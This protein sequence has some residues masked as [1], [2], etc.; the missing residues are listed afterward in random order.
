MKKLLCVFVLINLLP[1]IALAF[2]VD[3]IF[4]WD[5]D[6][7]KS[8][9]TFPCV[10]VIGGSN[11]GSYVGWQ[12]SRWGDYD[13]FRQRVLWD[14][15]L[16]GS[17]QMI[18]IDDF[19][20]YVQTSTDVA[21]NP[22]NYFVAVWEDSSYRPEKFT[23]IWC[24]VHTNDP[25]L[26]YSGAR[27]QKRPS[28]GSRLNGYF[29]VSWT[30]YDAG[31]YP[32]VYC[33]R[34]DSDG[35]Y[36][37]THTVRDHDSIR[38]YVPESR[39]AF[40]DSGFIVVYEDSSQDGTSRS[41]YGQ[42]R[43]P[44]GALLV[45]HKKLSHLSGDF[46]N[47]QH[48]DVAINEQGNMVVVWQDNRDGDW[49]IYAQRFQA[50]RNDFYA[51]SSEIS[52]ASTTIDQF[53]PR[54]TVFPNGDFVVVWHEKTGAD[55]DVYYRVW[56][57]G[58]LRPAT[59]VHQNGT[60]DQLHANCDAR[61]SE[62]MSIVWTSYAYS[63][64]EDIFIRHFKWDDGSSSGL[65]PITAD[66]PA[67]PIDP[68]TVG[69]RRG[70]YFDNENYDN[71]ATTDWDEDPVP[72]PESVYVDLEF[73]LVDQIM[74][75]NTNG[76]YFVAC[77]E[78]LPGRE[79][80]LL[81]AYEAIFLDLGYRTSTSSAGVITIDEQNDLVDYISPG[82][83]DGKPTMVEGNDFGYMY[84]ETA[85]YD[86]Y[87][88][89]YMGDGAP[90]TDGNIDTLYGV[91]GMFAEDETLK[92][93]Y[94]DLVDNYVDSLNA[95]SPARNILQSSG[96]PTEWTAV[97][98]VG[99][100]ASWEGHTQRAQGSI[101]YNSFMLSSIKSNTHPHTYAEYYRRCLGFLGLNCQ[102]EP[103]T[104]LSADTSGCSEGHV[105]IE[106]Q[107]V[108]DDK[109]SESAEGGYKL[110]FAREKMESEAAFNNAEEYYQN[111]N[112]K[113]SAVGVWVTQDLYG[114]PPLDTLIFAL[115]V[116]DESDLWGALG[117]EPR[118]VV[119]GDSVS[120]HTVHIAGNYVKDFSNKFEL[121]NKRNDDSLFV[122]WDGSYFYVGFSRCD[123]RDSG[124]LFIYLDTKSGGT[125]ST[126]GY[127]GSS[128]RSYFDCTFRPDYLFILE[129]NTI[130]YYKKWDP[131][132][133]RGSWVDTSFGTG[134]YSED[135]V[136]NDYLYTEVRIPFN[137][138]GYNPVNQ[139]KL[140]VLVQD[141]TTNDIIN[142][143]P[144]DNPLGT[145]V[146]LTQYY[147][148]V[149]LGSDLVPNRAVQIIGIDEQKI[150]HEKMMSKRLMAAPNPFSETT[151]II[152]GINQ[153]EKVELKIYDVTGRIVKD[154]SRPT[155]YSA[156]HPPHSMADGGLRSSP[157]SWDGC[158]DR[159]NSL[160]GGVYFCEFVAGERIEIEKIIYIK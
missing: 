42:Y 69:G 15:S 72:E 109:P 86:L 126:M 46:R 142:A 98:S 21:S 51:V 63:D 12:D 13:I 83:G 114:L 53:N 102:P 92:Y 30:S 154:F 146:D 47:E 76:Q 1:C 152:F 89:Q 117:A 144:I 127:N 158:D 60:N 131:S 100:G 4:V 10:G 41:I 156:T 55:L 129:D 94:Q 143:Y 75:L 138:M 105:I 153:Q 128:G 65:T 104:T 73:A 139:F 28:V 58:E 43:S 118:A 122:T 18:S 9:Q 50:T 111:W 116:S 38:A 66:I 56:I 108:S 155:H 71:P 68:D 52:M 107:V 26:V 20:Q 2:D 35:N 70:W 32:V 23:E 6:R 31:T 149:Y 25:F 85:L 3:T 130:S 115:K 39:V 36:L 132:D 97:R 49:N 40:C 121:L 151:T 59:V 11:N 14:G 119:A 103:I 16:A 84:D 134:S 29:V 125:D 80:T 44:D 133:N 33:R 93:D 91:S 160:P 137:I 95:I 79:R 22:A 48:S 61:Y 37:E 113:D 78:T 106:W 64:Y 147:Y 5:N 17:N 159:N 8:I 140:V 110:K 54:A 136:V 148:W 124:D 19:N 87:R 123:F 120:P 101:I 57:A 74:E 45:D 96:A 145:G 7:G 150:P 90:Y 141:E 62:N 77:A 81:S 67:I 88:A 27:S 112:T 34:Y 135:G 82:V 24:R 157:I 99:W